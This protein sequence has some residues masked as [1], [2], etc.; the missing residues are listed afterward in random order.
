[1]FAL[2]LSVKNELEVEAFGS[3]NSYLSACV[4]CFGLIQNFGLA[5]KMLPF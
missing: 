3:T 4:V 2:V 5:I 1:M